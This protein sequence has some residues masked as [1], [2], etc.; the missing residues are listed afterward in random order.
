MY[1]FVSTCYSW[2][3]WGNGTEESCWSNSSY[4]QLQGKGLVI[5]ELWA[6]SMFFTESNEGGLSE[7]F[8]VSWLWKVCTRWSMADGLATDVRE[9]C[10]RSAVPGYVLSRQGQDKQADV[11]GIGRNRDGLAWNRDWSQNWTLGEIHWSHHE[12]VLLMYIYI[13]KEIRKRKDT[14]A[15][16]S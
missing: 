14:Q 13:I 10:Q 1:V 6:N 5:F 8:D 3:C 7:C 15:F 16:R 9:L 2:F 11:D 4:E 12:F